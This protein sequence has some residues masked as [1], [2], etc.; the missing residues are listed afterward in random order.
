MNK[1]QLKQKIYRLE[2]IHDQLESELWYM[3]KL[4]K[5]VGFPHGLISMKEIALELLQNETND[6]KE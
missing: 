3:D 2:F 6:P 4:L 5:S 1:T